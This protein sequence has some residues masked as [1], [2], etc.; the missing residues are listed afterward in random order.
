L[1]FLYSLTLMGSKYK[2]KKTSLWTRS[3]SF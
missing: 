2:E 1:S 3:F